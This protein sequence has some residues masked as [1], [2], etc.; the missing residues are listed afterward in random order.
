MSIQIRETQFGLLVRYLSSNKILQYSDEIDPS[1]WKSFLQRNK[2]STSRSVGRHM[3][4]EKLQ[5]P[6]DS[7]K[8]STQKLDTP[9]P[10]SLHSNENVVLENDKDV[11]IV[12]WYGPDDPEVLPPMLPHTFGQLLLTQFGTESSK[13]VQWL[14]ATSLF[15]NMSP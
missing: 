9:H 12:D 14:E 1:I 10:G 11:Y 8:L 7:L 2:T 4:A 3:S 5:D 13:L 6:N 15:S